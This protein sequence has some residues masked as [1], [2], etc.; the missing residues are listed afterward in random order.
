MLIKV[1]IKD[2]NHLL[3]ECRKIGRLI[4]FVFIYIY[5]KKLGYRYKAKIS[6]GY[7]V[8]TFNTATEILKPHI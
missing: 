8:L 5:K 2:D 3:L 6:G 4:K 1:T 7:P